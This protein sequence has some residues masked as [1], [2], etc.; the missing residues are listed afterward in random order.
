M[1]FS[2]PVRYCTPSA[3][4]RNDL[5]DEPQAVPG[6]PGSI[7]DYD[8]GRLLALGHRFCLA[9]FAFAFG[10]CHEWFRERERNLEEPSPPIVGPYIE[11]H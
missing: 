1:P 4:Y 3:R 5:V 8:H 9:K 11:L 7:L 2:P 10:P 6:S